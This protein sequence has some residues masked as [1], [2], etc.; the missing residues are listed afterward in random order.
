MRTTR[1]MVRRRRPTRVWG[2]SA[3]ASLCFVACH[4]ELASSPASVLHRTM[5]QAA[6]DSSEELA[7][8]ELASVK[9]AQ[10]KPVMYWVHK[11]VYLHAN[12]QLTWVDGRADPL[13][14]AAV[15][16]ARSLLGPAAALELVL[17]GKEDDLQKAERLRATTHPM[18]REVALRSITHQA[19]DEMLQIAVSE[20]STLSG[21]T[22]KCLNRVADFEDAAR[23]SVFAGR[24]SHVLRRERANDQLVIKLLPEMKRILTAHAR[25]CTYWSCKGFTHWDR[26]GR[27]EEE[28]CWS[29]D[30][31]SFREPGAEAFDKEWAVLVKALPLGDRRTELEGHWSS[32]VDQCTTH[33][34]AP[35]GK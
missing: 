16:R 13:C 18:L 26:F 34:S 25:L 8:L 23:F 29:G 10:M 32:A 22:A 4:P 11:G 33:I 27:P 14:D 28:L 6:I 5:L 1:R 2:T 17:E 35:E 21:V 7:D 30:P 24:G 20:C 3:L 31:S 12:N 15:E 9:C 19:L